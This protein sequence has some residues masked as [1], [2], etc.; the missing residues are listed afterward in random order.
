MRRFGL[1][2]GLGIAA[3]WLA[4]RW[5]A[6]K[7][8]QAGWHTEALG[9][10]ES[11]VIP[12]R[13]AG[14]PS[15]SQHLLP[16]PSVPPPDTPPYNKGGG[17]DEAP[18]PVAP[19]VDRSGPAPVSSQPEPL[20]NEPFIAPLPPKSEPSDEGDTSTGAAEGAS[21]QDTTTATRTGEPQAGG[22]A[23]DKTTT[24]GASDDK[25]AADDGGQEQS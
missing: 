24:R 3:G 18:H 21:S 10:D 9:A 16:P 17:A 1:G 23:A 20:V 22:E 19:E 15:G 14:E 2:L 25:A 8:E 5:A 13:P 6:W 11:I 12:L 7:R 4:L